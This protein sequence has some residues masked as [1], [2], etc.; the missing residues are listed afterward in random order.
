MVINIQNMSDDKDENETLNES[1]TIIDNGDRPFKVDIVNKKVTIN[2]LI[3]IDKNGDFFDD[4]NYKYVKF[5]TYTPQHVFIGCDNINKDK[6]VGNNILLH[7]YDMHYV[8]I[9]NY[10]YAFTAKS[11]IV[12]F[13]SPMGGSLCPTPFAVDEKDNVYLLQGDKPIIMN[14]TDELNLFMISNKDPFYDYYCKRDLLTDDKGYVA[15]HA[16]YKTF[17]NIKEFYIGKKQ[18]TLRYSAYPDITYSRFLD[19]EG[20]NKHGISLVYHCGNKKKIS[21]QEFIDMMNRFGEM[22][23]FEKLNIVMIYD[24]I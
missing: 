14:S 3:Q 13:E 22:M 10:I 12:R 16:V 5:I 2:E 9:S 19:F 6:F 23:K 17:E 18:Y 7:M 15:A 11:K 20:A 4:T 21:K 1:Y 8:L 24:R